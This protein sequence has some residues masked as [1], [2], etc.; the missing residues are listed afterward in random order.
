MLSR[1]NNTVLEEA[2]LDLLVLSQARVL[3]GAM[4]S[5]MPRLALQMRVRPSGKRPPYISL[6]GNSWCTTS[7]CK[8]ALPAYVAEGLVKYYGLVAGGGAKGRNIYRS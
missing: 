5:N 3:A 6:D 8:A 1:E 7:S 4:L 2:L